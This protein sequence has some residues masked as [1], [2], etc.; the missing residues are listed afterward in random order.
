MLMMPMERIQA[1]CPVHTGHRSWAK[2]SALPLL[3]AQ[4]SEALS[5]GQA[6][7]VQAAEVTPGSIPPTAANSSL[8]K[9]WGLQDK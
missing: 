3:P 2:F 4:K 5:P 6:G 7:A 9:N 8:G 1:G